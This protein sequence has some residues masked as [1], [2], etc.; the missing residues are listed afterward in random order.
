M[1]IVLVLVMVLKHVSLALLDCLFLISE[2]SNL[3]VEGASFASA[4]VVMGV[5]VVISGQT[6]SVVL[7]SE[8]ENEGEG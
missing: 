5:V 7:P 3:F 6:Q 2:G 4:V 1:L 8:R